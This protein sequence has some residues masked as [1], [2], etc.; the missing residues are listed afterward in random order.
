M[1]RRNGVPHMHFTDEQ[2]RTNEIFL[3]RLLAK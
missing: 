3:A 1:A 2:Q